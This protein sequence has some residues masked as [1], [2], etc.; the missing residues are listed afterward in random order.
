METETILND[1]HLLLKSKDSPLHQHAEIILNSLLEASEAPI[2]SPNIPTYLFASL[3]AWLRKS[4][5]SPS[6]TIEKSL[7]S[8]LFL[9]NLLLPK[10]NL[11]II[12]AKHLEISDISEKISAVFPKNLVISRYSVAIACQLLQILPLNEWI[13][14]GG[15]AKPLFSRVFSA[16]L[17]G[18]SQTRRQISKSFSVL[19]D[20]A[21]VYPHTNE[22][23]REFSLKCLENEGREALLITPFLSTVLPKLQTQV[24][25]DVVYCYMRLLAKI[26]ENLLITHIYLCLE[27]LMSKS[28][29]SFELSESLLKELLRNQ[30]SFYSDEKLVFAYVQ[31]L[32]QTLVNLLNSQF[33]HAKRFISAVFSTISEVLLV[34]KPLLVSFAQKTLEMVLISAVKKPL[35]QETH[36]GLQNFEEIDEF[37]EMLDLEPSDFLR[38]GSRRATEFQK[39]VASLKHLLSSRFSRVCAESFAILKTFF[40]KIEALDLNIHTSLRALIETLVN[41]R[42]NVASLAKFTACFL[43]VAEKWGLKQVLE[44]VPLSFR[45]DVLEESFEN[46]NNLWV[47]SLNLQKHLSHE[48]L[49]LFFETFAKVLQEI[50]EKSQGSD[51]MRAKILENL[52]E[53]V[54]DLLPCFCF[55]KASFSKDFPRVIGFLEEFI[56][57]N[58]KIREKPAVSLLKMINNLRKDAS[59]TGFQLAETSIAEKTVPKLVKLV[60]FPQTSELSRVSLRAIRTLAGFCGT[61]Y[62]SR[63]FAKNAASLLEVSQNID[64]K[65]VKTFEILLAVG[66]SVD[67]RSENYDFSLKLVRKF[68]D[69]PNVLQK[70]AYKLLMIVFS[71]VHESFRSSLLSLVPSS[72][73]N[74]QPGSKPARLHVLRKC[75]EMCAESSEKGE[76]LQKF[77]AEIVLGLKENKAKCR[78]IAGNL[79]KCVSFDMRTQGILKEFLNL[80]CAGLAGVSFAMKAAS[81]LAFARVFEE[82][83]N[84][85]DEDFVEETVK[86]ASLLV[87]E[88]NKEVFQAFC[89]IVKVLLRKAGGKL[90][91]KV[92]SVVLETILRENEG[93][94][95]HLRAS[96]NHLL[97]KMI[98]TL[99][100]ETV[101]RNLPAGKE[102]IVRM[103]LKS[104]KHEKKREKS[105]RNKRRKLR[106]EREKEEKLREVDNE[107]ENM[108]S[109]EIAQKNQ[110]KLR[111]IEE[112]PNDLLLK[113]DANTE[114]FHFVE[115]PLAKIK[116]KARE[117]EKKAQIFDLHVKSG[118]I[119]VTSEETGKKR[120]RVEENEEKNEV[121]GKKEMKLREKMGHLVKES[122]ETFRNKELKAQGDLLI[123]GKPNPYAFIQLNPQVLNKRKRNLAGKAFEK[124]LG[125]KHEEGALKGLKSKKVKI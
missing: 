14:A 67:I 20:R 15:A 9:L 57:K 93:I 121:F 61:A 83:L 78:K 111:E 55:D 101:Q 104:Q 24:I 114:K 31:C 30:P 90:W 37:E 69:L 56:E 17:A 7:E 45:G 122:G 107:K 28:A 99:G 123:P 8:G 19:L 77:L 75:W 34:E 39:L 5:H 10:L 119:V 86:L 74:L 49:Q 94:R 92:I 26:T 95:E 4:L 44:V 113:Y 58:E 12:Q 108:M 41:S 103:V 63:V 105:L 51:P 120:K 115:H 36:S 106:R 70:R 13:S 87:S 11:A 3:Y 84:E 82:F 112:N 22:F 81:F 21:D 29:I 59:F 118:K 2:A 97:R 1:L 68:I 18:N 125:K 53:R 65:S 48:P 35:W 73:E 52:E 54:W 80:L 96:V 27:S 79:L 109:E 25:G 76:F 88:G 32:A 91:E 110:R 50:R 64:E 60:N 62:L 38:K 98:K 117:E 47:L 43:K 116:E 46:D 100:K 40:E 102:N 85:I 23:L 6:E 124:V 72:V 33:S 42:K 66:E 16:F 71:K 89:A